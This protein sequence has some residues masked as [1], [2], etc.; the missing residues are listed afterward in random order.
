MSK[1][2]AFKILIEATSQLKLT[3][4]EHELV[5][6]ALEALKPKEEKIENLDK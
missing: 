3:R 4:Q 6:K 1:E 5:L 2:Q